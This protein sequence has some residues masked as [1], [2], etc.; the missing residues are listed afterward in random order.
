MPWA[1][2][3][4]KKLL[5]TKHIRHPLAEELFRNKR[6]PM[7]TDTKGSLDTITEFSALQL[8]K[9]V[10][11][12]QS[13]VVT[14]LMSTLLVSVGCS[15]SKP[16]PNDND[17]TTRAVL[18]VVAEYYGDYLNSHRGKPPK[19][20][21]DFHEYLQSRAESLKLFNVESPDQLFKSA[22]DNRPLVIVSGKVIAPPDAPRSPW[23][24]FEQK[25]ID[26]KRLGVRVRGGIHEL[27]TDEID[28]LFSGN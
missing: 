6:W 27:T 21:A 4:A 23:A 5:I 25:G 9:L 19:D 14:L 17:R 22:R 7:E 3:T 18:G 11:H 13:M 28:Q 20:N 16:D 15:A 8:P 12:I 2:A 1:L 26:G 10:M 24:A